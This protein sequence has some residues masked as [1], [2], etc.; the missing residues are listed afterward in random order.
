MFLIFFLASLLQLN[1]QVVPME[2][3]LM[4]KVSHIH[5]VIKLLDY[6]EKADS[7]IIIMERP[8]KVKDLFD[9]ITENEA[10]SEDISRDFFRQILDTVT[11]VHK[12]GVVHRDIKDENILVD[13]KTGQLKVI[14]FGSGA[15]LRDTVYV[16]FDGEYFIL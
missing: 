16:D 7:F 1:G 13:L 6:Y 4:K 12:A 9:Y 3:C 5:G 2:I 14:D 11:S 10:L 8:E 15:F